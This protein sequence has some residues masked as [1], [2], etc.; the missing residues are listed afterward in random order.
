MDLNNVERMKELD[1]ENMIDHIN[2]LPEQLFSAWQLGQTLDLPD[3]E[4]IDNILISGM[5]GSAIGADL[6][7]TY[8][9][10][11]C[12]VPITVHRDYQLPAWANNDRTLV[13]CSSHSGNTEEV[14]T[15]L[16][17]VLK[18]DR[19]VMGISTG[20]KLSEKAKTA[21]FPLW[22]FGHN[23]QPRTAVGCS[24][25][26]LLAIFFRL[27]LIP[28]PSSDLK[29]T[30]EEMKKQQKDLLPDVP[31]TSNP[32]K[33]LA[34]QLMGR[35]ITFWGAESMAPIA[36]R[37]KGQINEN[38]KVQ[39]SFEILPEADHNALQ[40]IMQPEAQFGATMNIFLLSKD[41]HPRNKIRSEFTRMT[42]MLEGQNTDFYKA[43]GKSRL[44]QMWTTIH[45]GD[46][47]SYYL[48]IGYGVDPSPVPML[49]E[50]KE[51][52]KDAK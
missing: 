17:D 20:G 38:A 2:R 27:G 37:W 39:A 28:D 48:A 9:R 52:M 49:V 19:K 21:S 32:S 50:L 51:K 24:F 4:G 6:L 46:Y 15:V 26:L 29:E 30:I 34:G 36:R 23:F 25:G 10:P 41:N 16:E 18:T 35:W 42:F 13:I 43:K 47:V 14:L 45:F 8:V 22:L 33:R 5:G 11:F 12:S 40:G 31:D 7:A 44:A 3:W 1:P